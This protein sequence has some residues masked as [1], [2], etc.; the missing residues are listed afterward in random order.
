ML[1]KEIK[2]HCFVYQWYL[3]SSITVIT[4]GIVVLRDIPLQKMNISTM[5]SNIAL[6]FTFAINLARINDSLVIILTK[7]FFIIVILV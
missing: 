7:M 5:D 6:L 4:T 1:F 2:N 3:A